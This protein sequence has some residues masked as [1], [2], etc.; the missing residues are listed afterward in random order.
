MDRRNF[1]K[2]TSVVAGAYAITDSSIFANLKVP[3]DESW[4]NRPMRWA[5]LGYMCA[6]SI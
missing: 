6:G 2:T 4:F 5:Q 3:A 1:I